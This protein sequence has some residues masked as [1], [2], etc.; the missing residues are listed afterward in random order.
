M[1]S[2]THRV[3][4]TPAR[5]VDNTVVCVDVTGDEATIETGE[6]PAYHQPAQVT[7]LTISYKT[8]RNMRDNT[9][10]SEV[11]DITYRITGKDYDTTSIHPEYLDQPDEWPVWVRALVEE[12][13][14]AT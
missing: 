11:T 2:S 14:P 8:T 13:N 3:T 9:M 10:T 1:H 12:H 4:A 7:G 6:N 5:R